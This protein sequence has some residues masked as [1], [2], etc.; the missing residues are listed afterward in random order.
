MKLSTRSAVGPIEVKSKTA[1]PVQ[2]PELVLIDG[3]DALNLCEFPLAALGDRVS[4]DQKTL[5]FEDTVQWGGKST[6]R[7]LI[8]AASEKYGL[9]TALDDEVILGLVQLTKQRQF[10]ERMIPFTRYDLIQLLGWRDEGRSYRRI[11]E[12]LLR[13]VS[14]TLVYEKAWWDKE[15]KSFVNESFHILESVTLYDRERRD[16]RRTRGLGGE[17]SFT[18]NEV[19]FRS[20]EA[21]YLKKLDLAVYR[22]LKSAVAKRLYRFLDKRVYHRGTWEFELRHLCCDKL[23]MSRRGHTGELKRVLLSGIAELEEAGLVKR[24]STEER[25]IKEKAG[26]WKVILEEGDRRVTTHRSID[27]HPLV[28]ELVDRGVRSNAAR[29]LVR[30]HPEPMIKDRIA[31]HDYLVSRKDKRISRSSTGFLIQSIRH[32]YPLP[33]EFVRQQQ[34]SNERASRARDLKGSSVDTVSDGS[35]VAFEDFWESLPSTAREE[36]ELKAVR[37]AVPFLRKQYAEHR[38]TGGSLFAA[39]R[40]A[41]LM[42]A[43]RQAGGLKRADAIKNGTVSAA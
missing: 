22:S 29:L 19:V 33:S 16:R 10:R 30:R 18:W 28:R 3:R 17:S 31:F 23:G 26:V 34:P 5:Q 12:A 38:P 35:T 41:I 39:V 32:E 8:V 6:T 7:R 11:E 9:P 40:H 21:G 43:F 2:R 36:F 1:G 20:F 24:R 42:N 13:W 14:V 27:L 37:E 25:F 15:E 4:R